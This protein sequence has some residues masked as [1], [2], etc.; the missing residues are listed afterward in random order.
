[1][2]GTFLVFRLITHYITKTLQEAFR[3]CLVVLETVFP[4]AGSAGG[5]EFTSVLIL[6]ILIWT[7]VLSRLYLTG[8]ISSCCW[9]GRKGPLPSFFPGGSAIKHLAQHTV[10]RPIPTVVSLCFSTGGEGSC[11]HWGS[12]AGAVEAVARLYSTS[13][14]RLLLYLHTTR[15]PGNRPLTLRPLREGRIRHPELTELW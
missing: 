1:M 3:V 14:S 5:S 6:Q 8:R 12:L 7:W 11:G 15:A 4:K 13:P 10:T 2:L 9:G